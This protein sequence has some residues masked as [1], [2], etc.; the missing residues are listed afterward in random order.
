MAVL[1]SDIEKM[2]SNHSGLEQADPIIRE[3]GRK[4]RELKGRLFNE[5]ALLLLA[6][7]CDLYEVFGELVNIV[8][9]VRTLP[10]LRYDKFTAVLDKFR[11]MTEHFEDSDCEGIIDEMLTTENEDKES[12]KAFN[13]NI[14]EISDIETSEDED[15]EERMRRIE[16]LAAGMALLQATSKSKYFV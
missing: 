14:M 10:H 6:G 16:Q 3:K 15:K 4:A 13:L 1:E 8:Q 9:E 5:E 12:Y 11:K 7:L 2:I